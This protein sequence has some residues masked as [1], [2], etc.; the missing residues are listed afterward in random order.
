MLDFALQYRKAIDAISADR[1]M[2]LRQFE[3]SVKEWNIATQLRD[4]LKVS[5]VVRY[6]SSV[7]NADITF[8]A[9]LGIATLG[10]K[11]RHP[12]LLPFHSELSHCHT[13][14]GHYRREA[15][16]GLP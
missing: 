8:V 3:L 10:I 16:H 6:V 14:Y 7:L 9:R 5:S 1:E 15:Y 11:G 12:F 4:V 2:G 13:C